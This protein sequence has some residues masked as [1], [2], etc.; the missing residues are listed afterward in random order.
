MI[1]S[2]FRPQGGVSII[3]EP[4]NTHNGSADYLTRLI[5]EVRECGADAIKFQIFEPDHLAVPDFEW[6]PVYQKLALPYD[7]WSRLITLASSAGLHV[8]AEVFDREA[9][10][11]CVD[12]DVCSFKLNIADTFNRPLVEYLAGATR[13]VF[14]SVGGS[15]VSEIHGALTALGSGGAE[16]ILNYGFQSYPTELGF[17]NLAKIR[18]LAL[19][20]G[21][22]V[23]FADHLAGDHPLAIDL[24][25]LA[26]A[27]GATSIEKHV[28]LKR[29]E[30]R[31]DFYSSL[32]PHQ[33]GEMVSRVRAVEVCLGTSG[34][35]LDEAELQYREQ[36]RKC[37][38]LRR[39]LPA[40]YEL[41][42]ADLAFKRA[43]GRKD[44]VSLDEVVGRTLAVS[45]LPNIPVHKEHLK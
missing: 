26:V 3:A 44:F 41:T 34:L 43:N 40:G 19:H 7:T 30:S 21:R 6:Y 8:V 38:V 10:A 17:S 1:R 45:L 9:A 4:A 12:Y 23:C 32:E 5:A 15:L 36:H 31:Y 29:E 2:A 13:T 28:I 16:L 37:A 35:E 39:A 22:P 25:C 20:C 27:A 11:F 18:L 24:P 33:F 14:L 42:Y